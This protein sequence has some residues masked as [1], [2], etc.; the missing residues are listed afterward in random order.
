MERRE[1]GDGLGMEVE[2]GGSSPSEES[3]RFMTV[4]ILGSSLTLTTG[5]MFKMEA[6]EWGGVWMSVDT[7]VEELRKPY[8]LYLP[9]PSSH[10]GEPLSANLGFSRMVKDNKEIAVS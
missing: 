7:F 2:R 5:G 8:T 3:E 9:A 1:D 4:C 10:R 6:D